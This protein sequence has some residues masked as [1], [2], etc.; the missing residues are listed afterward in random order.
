[1]QLSIITLN[2]RKP[3][4]TLACIA[5]LY[6]TYSK[7]FAEDKF[8]VII[9]DNFSQDNSVEVIKAELK[10]KNYKNCHLL[11]NSKNAGFGAGNNFGVTKAKGEAVVFLNNDTEVKDGLQEMLNFL[12]SHK[13]V[14]ILGGQ[15]KNDDGSLQNSSGKFYTL[16]NL[17]LFLLGL[18]NFGL[19]D[20]SPAHIAEVDW[21][22]G[23]LL[24]IRREAF[25][26]LEGFD[27][28]IFMYLEDMELCFRA[29][30]K[31]YKVFFYPNV[32]IIHQDQGSSNRT[33]A[34]INIYKNMLYFYA[35]HKS[36]VE[37]ILA[38]YMLLIKAYFVILVGMLLNKK[39][40]VSRYKAA[41][42]F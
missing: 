10:K 25:E 12:M 31:G 1:M 37:Y 40:L 9:V 11:E 23:A 16:W 34:I 39:E 20:K 21:V 38:K 19:V 5:S 14:T 13:E 15:L 7:E 30:K 36:S 28:H 41:I 32:N 35:K 18:Q 4:L 22:K 27:E 2:F 17:A 3:L 29:R 6:K 42:K 24:M 8:E 26:V 33:F